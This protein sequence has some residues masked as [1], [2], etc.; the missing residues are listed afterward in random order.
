MLGSAETDNAID[1]H[2]HTTVCSRCQ[3]GT[4]SLTFYLSKKVV[5]I[6]KMIS[7]QCTGENMAGCGCATEE[8]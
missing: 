7:G 3:A 6:I 2:T 1:T 8:N 4:L 5:S